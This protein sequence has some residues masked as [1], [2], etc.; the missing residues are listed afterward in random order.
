[1]GD[2][3]IQLTLCCRNQN[4]TGWLAKQMWEME[5]TKAQSAWKRSRLNLTDFLTKNADMTNC[6]E[7]MYLM[8]CVTSRVLAVAPDNP[9]ALHH[10]LSSV[11]SNPIPLD[12]DCSVSSC[13][14]PYVVSRAHRRK[15]SYFK[16]KK[17]STLW[18]QVISE[19][20]QSS[21]DCMP[22][23]CMPQHAKL[24]ASSRSQQYI[25]QSHARMVMTFSS[26]VVCLLCTYAV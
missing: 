9:P 20:V 14:L 3:T 25:Y 11:L 21:V 15:K 4:L 13:L 10:L 7:T 22:M 17:R 19:Q 16:A 18:C 24:C 2:C 23:V 6:L 12:D 8:T 5:A 26:T 1:M